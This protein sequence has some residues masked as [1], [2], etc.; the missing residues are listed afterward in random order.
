MDHG[1]QVTIQYRKGDIT[2]MA[3]PRKKE[4]YGTIFS[5]T[6]KWRLVT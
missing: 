2:N 1:L 6:A 5:A 3:S 4:S